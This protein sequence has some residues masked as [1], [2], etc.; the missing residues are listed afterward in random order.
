M[1]RQYLL[2]HIVDYSKQRYNSL[3]LCELAALCPFYLPR[4]LEHIQETPQDLTL[5]L[6][7]IQNGNLDQTTYATL[8]R[9][10]HLLLSKSQSHKDILDLL[11]S[12]MSILHCRISRLDFTL[13]L[14]VTTRIF[15]KHLME[16]DP[17]HNRIRDLK[18]IDT[19][20]STMVPSLEEFETSCVILHGVQNDIPLRNCYLPRL[21][22]TADGVVDQNMELPTFQLQAARNVLVW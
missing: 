22:S 1:A 6:E 15:T 19:Q 11:D 2:Q 20:F 4:A 12:Q 5:W 3:P 18:M 7:A 21:F 8:F 14:L 13:P 10:L 17:W 9:I 16:G